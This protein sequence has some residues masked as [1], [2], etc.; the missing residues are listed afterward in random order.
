MQHFLPLRLSLLV[1]L[2]MIKECGCRRG[3]A[4]GT[5]G[6]S[7]SRSGGIFSGLRR[8][9]GFSGSRTRGGVSGSVKAGYPHD[10][11]WG[12]YGG[13]NIGRTGNDRWGSSSRSSW[14]QPRGRGM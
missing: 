9:G 6:T 12:T 1:L 3:G 7:G 2:L 10:G 4:F 13:R 11:R 14:G 8:S 5:R